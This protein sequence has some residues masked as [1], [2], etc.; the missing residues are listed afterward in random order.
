MGAGEGGGTAIAHVTTQRIQVVARACSTAL[1]VMVSLVACLKDD[2]A[3][4][5]TN[6]SLEGA[7]IIISTIDPD[8]ATIDT[9]ITVRITGSGFTDGS[10]A[11]W[12]VD[13]TETPDIRTVSTTVRS[14][15]EIEAVIAISPEAELRSYSVR[16]RGKKGKQ[17]IAVER[18]R[19][20][21]KPITLPEP[22]VRSAANDVNDSGVIVGWVADASD[23]FLATRWIPVDSGWTPTILGTGAAV[24]INNDGL[25]ARTLFDPVARAWHSWIHFPSGATVDLGPVSVIDI[26]NNGIIIGRIFDAA[27]Q[28]THV[29]WK[30]VTATT[31]GPPHVLPLPP[32]YLGYGLTK[33][34][35]VGDIVGAISTSN[36]STPGVWK[37]RDSEWRSPEPLE[38]QLP[39]GAVAINDAGAIAGYVL[40][41]VQGVPG[42]YTSAAFWPSAGAPRRILPTLY[43]SQGLVADINNADH[44]VGSAAVH[45][46]DGSGPLAGMVR[47]AVIWFPGGQWP[48]DLG[49]IQPERY[50]EAAAINN[51]GLVAGSVWTGIRP[52]ATA[53]KLPTGL[54]TRSLRPARRR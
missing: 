24:A 46:N 39:A 14:P 22:G 11:S 42:C 37:Y 40:P 30:Q 25:I 1:L 26:S 13:T 48:E 18:F 29:A 54:T 21:A 23:V 35:G 6:A 38:M 53:W 31:W 9:T 34:N 8:T 45:Y 33:I 20:V 12:L 15:G 36:V 41:C 2:D 44:V 7:E 28:P 17:G 43:N 47:H 52:H 32:G 3:T 27:L 5:I 49:A 10:S 51:H 4:G 16:I 50:G 19:V